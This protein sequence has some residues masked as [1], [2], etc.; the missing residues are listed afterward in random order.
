MGL[1]YEHPVPTMRSYLDVLDRALGRPRAGRRGERAPSCVHI[2][3][4]VTD[5]T[6]TPVLLA[7][8]GPRTLALC[9]ER[10]DGTILWLADERAIVSRT[11]CR[12]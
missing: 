7:A 4:D 6:P 3:L 1:P 9:G 12:A 8:L 5:I 11:S 2:P 10:T